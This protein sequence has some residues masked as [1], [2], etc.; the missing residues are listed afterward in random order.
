MIPMLAQVPLFPE[1]ASTIAPRVDGVTG[2]LV[3]VS[4]F[5]TLLICFLI[6]YFFIKYRRRS[7]DE[8]P[9]PVVESTRL[10]IIWT[11]VP[12]AISLFI[13]SYG[14]RVFIDQ[15]TPPEDAMD[16]YVVGKQWMW[17][18]QHLNGQRENQ[19]LHVPVGKPV[20]L[21]MASQDVIHNFAIPAF[22]V[23]MDVIPGR[24]TV[25]WFQATK[26]GKYHF[27]CAEYCGT[28]HSR[29]V[30][31]VHVM[32][33]EA[34]G[35]WLNSPQAEGSLASEGRQL[36]YKLECV[37]CHSSNA[38]A[39]APVLESIYGQTVPLE[40]GGKARVDDAYLHD[41]IRNPQKHIRQ[42]FSP[43][44]PSYPASKV[45]QRDLNKL[46]AFIRFLGP[47]QTPPRIEK[48]E[49]PIATEKPAAAKKS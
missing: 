20:R 37:T 40:G 36:F 5:F 14:T 34:F 9:H 47:G 29:M 38:L 13:F 35:K 44:M 39:R 4:G 2:L 18:V 42:G 11:L 48:S 6:F 46:I 28:N 41:A 43:I 22:R 26:P 7:P 19:E 24:Y 25:L 27:F 45:S 30:G 15:V 23:K 1:Q 32:E 8:Y 3:A 49:P 12:L 17:H 16:I 21:I 10:E 33:Q 31:W